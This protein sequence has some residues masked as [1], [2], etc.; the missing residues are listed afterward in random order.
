MAELNQGQQ[1]ILIEYCE[2]IQ[3]IGDFYWVNR[4]HN[5]FMTIPQFAFLKDHIPPVKQEGW[6][7]FLRTINN[8]KHREAEDYRK[9]Y[10]SSEEPAYRHIKE[11]DGKGQN[12]TPHQFIKTA[13]GCKSSEEYER[14]YAANIGNF[15]K[16]SI[17]PLT[18]ELIGLY[19]EGADVPATYL[20]NT[21]ENLAW[22][23]KFADKGLCDVHSSIPTPQDIRVNGLEYLREIDRRMENNKHTEF[24]RQDIGVSR[25]QE[26]EKEKEER[27][28]EKIQAFAARAFIA[29][30]V[31][32][33]FVMKVEGK[34]KD[35]SGFHFEREKDMGTVVLSKGEK[36][37]LIDT[38]FYNSIIENT[39]IL[40]NAP[41]VTPEV[42][43]KY[44]KAAELDREKLRPNT[45]SDFWHNYRVMCRQ[46][47]NNPSDAMKIA[48][49]ILSKMPPYEQMHFKR[50][51]KEYNRLTGS[52]DAYNERLVNFYNENVKDLPVKHSIFSKEAPRLVSDNY[53]DVIKK[54]G[55]PIDKNS[56]IKIG[57]SVKM[58]FDFQDIATGKT[59]KLPPKDYVVTASSE[60]KNKV[61]LV[62]KDSLSKYVIPRDEF[63]QMTKKQEKEVKKEQEKE[64]KK[65]MKSS[66][67]Y[68][69]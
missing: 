3:S 10:G 61:V 47:A 30:T 44:E 28:E 50:E 42:I 9:K 23:Y 13:L 29:G 4:T 17:R 57:E 21:P 41:A 64:S 60:D 26:T 27:E 5:E 40:A 18:P 34:F 58:S 22:L 1:K 63:L 53:L 51:I 36:K 54:P 65:E 46:S 14:L 67:A 8:I 35:F 68:S 6:E 69:Y 48:K 52:K 59:R 7:N 12:L 2:K 38:S 33:T 16:A 49:E 25:Q 11:A 24:H 20:P 31:V 19:N 32:P 37:I 66:L 55:E 62:D 45:A 15:N 43:A 56:S 39:K